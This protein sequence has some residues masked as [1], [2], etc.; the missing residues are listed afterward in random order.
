MFDRLDILV[1]RR[2][3]DML[4]ISVHR[5][6]RVFH[7]FHFLPLL[8]TLAVARPG[9]WCLLEEAL[10]GPTWYSSLEAPGRHA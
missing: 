1:K 4:N 5:D 9:L 3:I 7:T 6:C 8:A 10:G 2:L